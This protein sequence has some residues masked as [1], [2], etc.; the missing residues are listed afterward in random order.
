MKK[1]TSLS[2][3][4]GISAYNEASTLPWL[5]KS[6]LNQTCRS[7]NFEKII[8][9][10]DGSTD[11]TAEVIQRINSHKLKVIDKKNRAGKTSRVNE[12][13]ALAT[14]DVLVVL[15]ADIQLKENDVLEKLI[16]PFIHNNDLACVSGAIAPHSPKNITQKIIQTGTKLWDEV[17]SN[18]G[19][20][21][22]L[23]YCTGAIRAFRKRLYKEMTFP[24]ISAEDVYPY[25]YCK[26][27]N[28][29]FL[30]VPDS[31]VY[32]ETPRTYK[33]FFKQMRRYLKSKEVLSQHFSSQILASSFSI[34]SAGKLRQLVKC[35]VQNPI[36]VSAYLVYLLPAHFV[37]WFTKSTPDKPIWD[38]IETS[39]INEV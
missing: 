15:D 27:K 7:F 1:H 35:L 28:Y 6:L 2:V 12:L 23:Y 38:V 11:D 19:S 22:D 30:V 33:D 36:W 32:Y 24:H 16:V 39:K 17:R 25:L 5:I 14:S 4:V 8:I 20:T 31:V 10:S 9:I 13:F 34:S 3:S 26:V 37:I 18:S 21:K 29:Q